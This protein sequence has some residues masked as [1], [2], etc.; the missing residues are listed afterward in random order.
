MDPSTAEKEVSHPPIPE[1]KV[2]TKVENSVLQIPM[3]SP[4][5]V[6][7]VAVTSSAQG[8]SGHSAIIP[9]SP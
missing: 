4:K 9:Q 1:I 3:G 5:R 7:S 6:L 2:K 8:S